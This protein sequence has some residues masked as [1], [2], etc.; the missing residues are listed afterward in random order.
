MDLS[1]PQPGNRAVDS[2]V[3]NNMF[4]QSLLINHATNK[5]W[6]VLISLSAQVLLVAVATAIPL[7][8]TDHLPQFHWLQ[9]IGAPLT[10]APPSAPREDITIRRSSMQRIPRTFVA[11]RQIPPEIAHIIDDPGPPMTSP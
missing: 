9:V 4:E 1:L 10:P 8:F 11:P 7:V 3:Y 2:G 6:S 5:H